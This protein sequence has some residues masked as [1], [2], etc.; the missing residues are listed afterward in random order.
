MCF[1][2]RF[3]ALISLALP[4]P[5]EGGELPPLGLDVVDV[6]VLPGLDRS[7]HLADVDAVLDDG[8]AHA[9]V[10]QGDLV[11]ERDILRA[12]QADRAVLVQDETGQGLSRL[13]PFDHHD[14][15]GI[16]RVVQDTMDH[17]TAPEEF[18]DNGLRRVF[19]FTARTPPRLA[20]PLRPP[21]LA[22]GG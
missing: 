17:S 6:G 10:L 5:A 16:A 22:A 3:L 13:D 19:D 21:A 2:W 7:D 14:G 1:A 12:R 9:H 11:T 15:H 4:A 18:G 20:A 8:V